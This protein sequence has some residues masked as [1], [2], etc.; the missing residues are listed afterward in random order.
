MRLCMPTAIVTLTLVLTSIP[1]IAPGKVCAATDAALG[2]GPYNVGSAF[3]LELDSTRRHVNGSARPVPIIVFYPIHPTDSIGAAPARY[4]RNP[5]ANQASEVF[6]STNF[7]A[8]GLDAAYDSIVPSA[9]GPFPLLVMSNGA[10]QPYWYNLGI[11]LRVASHGFLVVLMG[12]YGEAAYASPGPSDPL[13]HVAQRGLDRILDVKFVIDRVLSRNAIPEDLLEGL[14]HVQKIAV[15]GHS[16]GGLTAVQVTGGDDLVCDT[17]NQANPPS[18]TCVPFLDVDTRIKATVLIDAPTQNMKYHEL[19]RVATANIMIG[20]D[21]DSIERGLATGDIAGVP[22]AVHARAHHAYSGDPN[23]RIDVMT[24]THV[25]SFTNAC[26]AMLVRGDIGVLTVAEVGAQL[27]RLHC[28]DPSYTPFQ[29]ANEIMWR[30]A[31]A[32]LKAEL[33]GDTM[34]GDLLT[35]GWAVAREPSVM[36]FLNERKNGQTLPDSEFPDDSWFHFS[37]PDDFGTPLH[38]DPLEEAI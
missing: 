32:F 24:T 7:E 1:A 8:R 11:A 27:A 22:L 2:R 14:V 16:F 9:D 3:S 25:A 21:I 5:F 30:Y 13:M 10:R 37:Q 6:L 29:T 19:A 23:Y 33:A 26:Q 4:P 18:V 15:G 12:H 36:F 20:E 17:Y 28:N 38:L 31:A 35:P 34:Y